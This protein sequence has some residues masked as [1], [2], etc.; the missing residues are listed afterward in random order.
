MDFFIP[1]I[2]Q[3]VYNS[4]HRIYLQLVSACPVRGSAA[5]LNQTSQVWILALLCTPWGNLGSFLICKIQTQKA[6]MKIKEICK[7]SRRMPPYCYPNAPQVSKSSS[8][9]KLPILFWLYCMYTPEAGIS[10][11]ITNVST[12]AFKSGASK[13]NSVSSKNMFCQDYLY[14]NEDC[15]TSPPTG[16]LDDCDTVKTQRASFACYSHIWKW[17][18][19]KLP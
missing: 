11:L 8:S 4:Y 3:N 14:L 17:A 16:H 10:Y 2:W 9:L 7:P 1:L 13:I 5:R 15:Y 18:V 12:L 19:N 6:F